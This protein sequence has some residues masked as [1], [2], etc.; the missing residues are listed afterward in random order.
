MKIIALSPTGFDTVTFWTSEDQP[1][2]CLIQLQQPAVCFAVAAVT[3][4]P[5]NPPEVGLLE[6][7]QNLYNYLSL[8]VVG[9][10]H[11][12]SEYDL[13][14]HSTNSQ[15]SAFSQLG[16]LKRRPEEV[17]EKLHALRHEV[18]GADLGKRL[19]PLLQQFYSQR[20]FWR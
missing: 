18:G 3:R 11:P 1:G 9:P 2:G 7:H 8:Q 6:V 20:H 14:F 5:A 15:I 10:H 4:D 12:L 16:G 13:V 17:Q 19:D